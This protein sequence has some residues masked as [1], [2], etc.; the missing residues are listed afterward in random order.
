[1]T[2]A[3]RLSDAESRARRAGSDATGWDARVLLAHAVGHDKPLALDPRGEVPAG[4]ASRFEELWERRLSGMPVQHLLGRWDF[5]GRPF[6][7]DSRA[8]VPRPETELLIETALAEAPGARRVLDLGT[9]GG[10]LAVTWLV[11]RADSRAVALDVSLEALALARTNAARHAVIVRLD[12][13]AGDWTS[14][15]TTGTLFDLAVSNP[16]YLALSEAADLSTTVRDHDPARALF[17]GADGLDAIRRLLDEVPAH[18]EN[19]APFLFEIG[20]GQAERIAREV[21]R[22]DAWRLDRIVPDLAAIPRV[23]VLRR[24]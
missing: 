6:L 2:V 11:E 13:F 14:A 7:V 20:A 1:V 21:A 23:A 19:G 8:L 22:R 4:A 12:L 10:I 16:P 5:F 17:A 3:E 24:T 15:L 18:L 9:G